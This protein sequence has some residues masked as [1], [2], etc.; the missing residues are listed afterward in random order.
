M[1]MVL[2]FQPSPLALAQPDAILLTPDRLQ[3]K[4]D[5]P[6]EF[7]RNWKYHPGDGVE[8]S[9]PAFDDSNW[10]TLESTLL[11]SRTMPQSGWTGIGWFRLHL[12]VDSSLW[13]VPLVLGY[14]QFGGAAEIYLDGKPLYR[15]GTVGTSKRTETT[16]LAFDMKAK[17]EPI[18]FG[19]QT[20]HLIAVRY[21]NFTRSSL[22]LTDFPMG[23]AMTV[24]GGDITDHLADAAE[25]NRKRTGYQF[26]FCGT[27]LA[28]TLLH[29][30][31]FSF[32]PQVR[33]NLYYAAFT[34]SFA[35]MTFIDFDFEFITADGKLL[36]FE[37]LFKITII[38]IG[39]SGCRFLYALFYPKLPK[40]FWVIF[41]VGFAMGLL[42]L[43]ISWD[44]I[45]LFVLISL[46]EMLRVIV[47]SIAR[48]KHGAWI[49]GIG[50]LIFIVGS[51]CSIFIESVPAYKYAYLSGVLGLVI[52][53]SVYLARR[54][55]Q[56]NKSLENQ[57][58][59]V[60]AL[61]SDLSD[62]NAQLEEYSR[63]LEQK[64]EQRTREVQEKQAQLV[65]S[66]K[67]ASLGNLV[68]GVAHE[69]NNPIGVVNSAADILN[70]GV[71]KVISELEIAE[72][73]DNRR[74][75][76]TLKVLQDSIRLIST[77]GERISTTV[78]S[79]RNFARLDEAEFQTA[80]IHEGLDS[81][82]ALLA[83][84]L[85]HKVKV[86]KTYGEIPHIECY[87]HQLNQAFMQVLVNAIE[88]IESEGTITI[89]TFA[90]NEKVYVQI[91]DTGRGIPHEHL[92]RIF[93]PGFTT[94]G[95]GVGTGLGLSISYNIVEKHNG[96]IDVESQPEAGTV[97]TLHLPIRAPILAHS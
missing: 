89:K 59:Q 96:Q 30:L 56:T 91:A 97:F 64:V 80:D 15:F 2:V 94:K 9:K 37:T 42:S 46:A 41:T 53:M 93:D 81:T 39:V 71:D 49:I 48:K 85:K 8:W 29:L 40:P 72:F 45:F 18:S 61:S 26:F 43:Y 83:H 58:T 68:A 13:S 44:Y 11:E 86:I 52:S 73:L 19:N 69:I 36:V 79:L 3:T 12:A 90:D 95:V 35:M 31:M 54:F 82:L 34:G 57:L 76:R 21:S 14:R 87:P 16:D 63:T 50:G 66:A 24:L 74:L 70:R 62:A 55:A 77:A 88:A 60:K 33:E 38:L 51:V 20:E 4:F 7:F 5:D 10:E 32:Y 28:F 84:E 17:I 78:R 47:L 67:M 1:L 23:F 6:T 27:L 22:W 75:N 65:Q 92:H 25:R